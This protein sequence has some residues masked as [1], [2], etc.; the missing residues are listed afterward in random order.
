MTALLYARAALLLQRRAT[1]EAV[2]RLGALADVCPVPSRWVLDCFD[3]TLRDLLL[4]PVA[5]LAAGSCTGQ[6]P[7]FYLILDHQ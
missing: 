5:F 2:A 6:P 3:L 1:S 7:F 4:S